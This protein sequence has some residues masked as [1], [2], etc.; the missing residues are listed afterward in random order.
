[1]ETR[2]IATHVSRFVVCVS[3]SASLCVL[4]TP[5]SPAKTAEPADTPFAGQ[6]PGPKKPREDQIRAT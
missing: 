1:M 6:T 5:V 4:R 2:P 3:L